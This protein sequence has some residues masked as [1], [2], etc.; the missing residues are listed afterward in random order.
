MKVSN[1][2]WSE[3]HCFLWV[4]TFFLIWVW[5]TERGCTLCGHFN[6]SFLVNLVWNSSRGIWRMRGKR[7]GPRSMQMEEETEPIKSSWSCPT[8]PGLV[9]CSRVWSICQMLC[10]WRNLLSLSWQ[11]TNANRPSGRYADV[12]SALTCPPPCRDLCL[13]WGCTGLARV[14]TTARNLWEHLSCYVWESF[15]KSS[16]TSKPYNPSFPFPI[17][18]PEPWG[19]W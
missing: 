5:F 14:V 17:E 3:G 4:S 19:C 2:P 11:W 18:L 13:T 1:S 12:H 8:T 10:H 7:D 15:R 16:A 9:A 6:Y